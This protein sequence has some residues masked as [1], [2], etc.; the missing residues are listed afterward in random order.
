M[1]C[2]PDG[3]LGRSIASSQ[4][5]RYFFLHP[6]AS[7]Q[8]EQKEKDFHTNSSKSSCPIQTQPHTSN[9]LM[10]PIRS[11]ITR[12]LPNGFSSKPFLRQ[13][14][15]NQSQIHI[16][17]KILI[18]SMKYL[19]IKLYYHQLNNIMILIM[20]DVQYSMPMVI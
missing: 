8:K 15:K 2:A 4:M 18:H 10:I 14:N 13:L 9:L 3:D 11:S 7:H 20:F 16:R 1:S 12:I 6:H 17:I 5:G 19:F